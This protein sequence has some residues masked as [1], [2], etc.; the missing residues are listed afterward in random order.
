M[1]KRTV[2]LVL[3]AALACA[4]A[5]AGRCGETYIDPDWVDI[6][7]IKREERL[8]DSARLVRVYMFLAVLNGGGYSMHIADGFGDAD[9]DGKRAL[10]EPNDLSEY[11]DVNETI[12]E[13]MSIDKSAYICYLSSLPYFEELF[14]AGADPFRTNSMVGIRTTEDFERPGRLVGSKS[15]PVMTA[16]GENA[17]VDRFIAF[18]NRANAGG[19]TA[20]QTGAD[21]VETG[22][23]P[24]TVA[25]AGNASTVTSFGLIEMKFAMPGAGE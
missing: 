16:D 20:A 12:P 11:E 3:A 24:E 8:E 13:P 1:M 17:G 4:I 5:P 19:G 10:D 15:V 18:Y 22:G 6:D 25:Q 14:P 2:S 7:Q 23:S 9:R 21:A